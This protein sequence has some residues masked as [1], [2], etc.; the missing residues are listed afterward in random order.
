[1]IFETKK[2]LNTKRKIINVLTYF[3]DGISRQ[4]VKHKKTEIKEKFSQLRHFSF[5][6]LPHCS[7]FVPYTK[8]PFIHPNFQHLMFKMVI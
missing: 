7:F 3:C 5:Q 4:N 6:N 1:M 2:K 8:A